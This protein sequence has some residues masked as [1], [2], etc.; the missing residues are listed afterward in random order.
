MSIRNQKSQS[1]SIDV[2]FGII[3]FMVAFFVFFIVLSEDPAGKINRLKE[4]AS[5]IVRQLVSGEELRIVDGTEVNVSRA[6]KL[7][8]IQYEE[9]KRRFRVEGDFCIYIEDSKGNIVLINNSYKGIGSPQ[10]NISGT[11]CSQK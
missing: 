6:S 9:L 11:L 7:K 4:E 1:W 2:I 3:V 10:I 5:S 8:D